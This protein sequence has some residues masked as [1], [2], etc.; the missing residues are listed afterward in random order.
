MDITDFEHFGK[1]IVTTVHV[2][3]NIIK[4]IPT[5]K[6]TNIM[7]YLPRH[8][9]VS[10]CP[11]LSVKESWSLGLPARLGATIP[12]AS[13]APFPTLLFFRNQKKHGQFVPKKPEILRRLQLYPQHPPACLNTKFTFSNHNQ[14]AKIKPTDKRHQIFW[15][16]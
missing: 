11:F 5:I 9:N 16:M 10:G 15:S 12:H 14:E 1:K 13:I 3:S 7:T 8:K 2:S 6:I 4:T